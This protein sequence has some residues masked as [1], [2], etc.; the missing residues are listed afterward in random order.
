[1]DAVGIL[2]GVLVWLAVLGAALFYAPGGGGR[3]NFGTW[4][5]L[6]GLTVVVEFIVA[7]LALH[8][9]LFGLGTGAA[10]VGIVVAVVVLAATPIAWA[11]VL[12]RRAHRDSA[13]G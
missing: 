1:M 5:V 8:A 13:H 11:I 3:A 6:S 7:F 4:L 9:L 10:S 2:L 12:R